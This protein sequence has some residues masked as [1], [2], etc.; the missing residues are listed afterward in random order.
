MFYK[1]VSI[2]YL[3]LSQARPFPWSHGVQWT[4][5]MRLEKRQV[6]IISKP[7]ST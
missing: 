6:R 7:N 1:E 2:P 4:M 5:I 3:L